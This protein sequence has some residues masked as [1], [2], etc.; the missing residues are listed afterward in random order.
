MLP[1]CAALLICV[2]MCLPW[3]ILFSFVVFQGKGTCKTYWLISAVKR[4]S[5]KVNKLLHPNGQPLMNYLNAPG[6]HLG[7]NS[8]LNNLKRT[9]SL[10]RSMKASP[11]SVKK[12][13]H[14]ADDESAALLNQ[15]SVWPLHDLERFLW[16]LYNL[17]M[18]SWSKTREGSGDCSEIFDRFWYCSR[19]I[20]RDLSEVPKMSRK[21]R[22]Y[23]GL[24]G[25]SEHRQFLKCNGIAAFVVRLDHVFPFDVDLQSSI[26]VPKRL[27]APFAHEDQISLWISI[28][29]VKLINYL[30]CKKSLLT[31][32]RCLWN[33]NS[34][35]ILILGTRLFHTV[36]SFE[37]RTKLC[38]C[39]NHVEEW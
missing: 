2:G 1:Y 32:S 15:T 22:E 30:C 12:S 10:R 6:H 14:K 4:T 36:C 17:V 23:F 19:R 5:N 9:E 25:A 26:F 37:P 13:W 39:I 38:G 21:W 33:R 3:Y 35:Y 8:S 34:V 28:R 31:T 16:T 24:V 29:I 11:N 27:W 18:V 7:S 20:L